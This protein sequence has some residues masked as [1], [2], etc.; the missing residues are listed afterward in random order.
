MPSNIKSFAE[1]SLRLGNARQKI[2]AFAANDPDPMIQSIKR[3]LE[4]VAQWTQGGQRPAQHDLDQLTF[5]QM[6]SR[7]VHDA[8]AE[9]AN[10]L[11]ELASYLIFWPPTN[12]DHGR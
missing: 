5:G 9:F 8:D 7:A 1:F 2:D 3:Q 4:F 11:Y 6:A 12:K 10:E